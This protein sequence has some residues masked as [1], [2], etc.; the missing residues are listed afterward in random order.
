M[1]RDDDYPPGMTVD[2]MRAVP[3]SDCA[4]CRHRGRGVPAGHLGRC[5]AFPSGDGIPF[6]IANG[7]LRHR[8]PYPGDHGV[9]YEPGEPIAR[10]EESP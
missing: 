7:D 3:R 8:D 5:T 6:A 1:P 2:D 9:R 4:T 10:G